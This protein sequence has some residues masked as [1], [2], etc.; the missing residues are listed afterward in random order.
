VSIAASRESVVLNHV[1]ADGPVVFS[2][3]RLGPPAFA[4]QP[5]RFQEQDLLHDAQRSS[6]PASAATFAGRLQGDTAGAG[7]FLTLPKLGP[8]P[9]YLGQ[10]FSCLITASNYG[11]A[12]LTLLGIKVGQIARERWNK[13]LSAALQIKLIRI[14]LLLLVAPPDRCALFTPQ[15]ELCTESRRVSLLYD[16]TGSPLPALAAG[17]GHEFGV[18]ADIKELVRV[19]ACVCMFVCVCCAVCVCGGDGVF[20]CGSGREGSGSVILLWKLGFGNSACLP[21]GCGKETGT[22]LPLWQGGRQAACLA[23]CQAK[24]PAFMAHSNHRAAT[25]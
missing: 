21:H 6:M 4:E 16:S 22:M 3:V 23:H 10:S 17:G 18:R 24:F 9:V 2:L 5:L 25:R 13:P 15:V 8:T 1:M 20:I 12:T 14:L 19:F 11:G 7:G